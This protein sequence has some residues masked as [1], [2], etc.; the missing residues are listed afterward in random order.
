MG[1]SGP[2]HRKVK[3]LVNE[4]KVQWKLREFKQALSTFHQKEDS[5]VVPTRF[6]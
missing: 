1:F 2:E 3:Q 4:L 5:Q 6:S